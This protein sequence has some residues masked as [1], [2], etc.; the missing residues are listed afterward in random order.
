[1]GTFFGGLPA[2]VDFSVWEKNKGEKRIKREEEEDRI[3]GKKKRDEDQI[4]DRW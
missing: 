2:G 1:M 4:R 3:V